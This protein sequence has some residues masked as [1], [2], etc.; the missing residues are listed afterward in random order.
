MALDF[1]NKVLI[2]HP[3]AFNLGRCIVALGVLGL[4]AGAVTSYTGQFF[5]P[6]SIWFAGSVPTIGVGGAFLACSMTRP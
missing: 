2:I 3:A 5:V 6:P 4:I 1:S